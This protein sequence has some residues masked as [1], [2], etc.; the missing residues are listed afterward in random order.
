MVQVLRAHAALEEDPNVGSCTHI[1][2]HNSL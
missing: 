2:A 1:E